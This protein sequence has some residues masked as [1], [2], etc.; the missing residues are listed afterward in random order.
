MDFHVRIILDHLGISLPH[1]DGFGKVKYSYTKSVYYSIYDDDGVNADETWMHGNW[2]Y[3][4]KYGIFGV[5][6]KAITMSPP[7]NVAQ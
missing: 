1:E 2:F 5:G 4:T 6:R 7:N 3:M